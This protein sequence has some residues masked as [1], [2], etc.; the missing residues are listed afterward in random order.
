ML[1]DRQLI[2]EHRDRG[3]LGF[4]TTMNR[5]LSFLAVLPTESATPV[6]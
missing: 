1:C 6:S 2:Y 5:P 4:S 3:I